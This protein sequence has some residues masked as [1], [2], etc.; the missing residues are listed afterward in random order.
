VH[1]YYPV[2]ISVFWE[3]LGRNW[4]VKTDGYPAI[5]KRISGTSLVDIRHCCENSD[6]HWPSN[7]SHIVVLHIVVLF[8][9]VMSTFVVPL[10]FDV[11]LGGI[12]IRASGWFAVR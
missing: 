8:V 4:I 6:Q 7:I 3:Q 2:Q 5:C 1:Y 11:W 9:T 10:L 12:I